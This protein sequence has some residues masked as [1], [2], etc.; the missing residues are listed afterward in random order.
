MGT[1]YNVVSALFI[2]SILIITIT[3]EEDM[4]TSPII[5]IRTVRFKGEVT[6]RKAESRALL[7]SF[8]LY[9]LTRSAS[10]GATACKALG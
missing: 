10:T 9:P 5:Q 4:C 8:I 3:S 1:I 2:I 7:H 6:C